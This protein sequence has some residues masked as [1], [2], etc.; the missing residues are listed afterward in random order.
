V[1]QVEAEIREVLIISP[2]LQLIIFHKQ[3]DI[4]L[5]SG[6]K[7][8]LKNYPSLTKVAKLKQFRPGKYTKHLKQYRADLEDKSHWF[9]LAD[10]TGFY[11]M[12]IKNTKGKTE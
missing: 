6:N 5:V 3:E 12:R 2:S 11:I 4:V 1:E 9:V 7:N 10:I 8:P